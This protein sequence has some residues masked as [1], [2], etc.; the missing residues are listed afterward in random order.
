MPLRVTVFAPANGGVI[1][2][3]TEATAAGTFDRYIEQFPVLSVV[4]DVGVGPVLHD[5][6]TST[7]A[8]GSPV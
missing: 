4:H 1:V 8:P 3:V 7:P 6:L 2:M 5:A